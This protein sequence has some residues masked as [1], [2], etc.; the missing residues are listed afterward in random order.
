MQCS[1]GNGFR[2]FQ[3]WHVGSVRAWGRV[4]VSAGRA[5]AIDEFRSNNRAKTQSVREPVLGGR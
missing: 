1:H 4:L 2:K 5:R 3:P